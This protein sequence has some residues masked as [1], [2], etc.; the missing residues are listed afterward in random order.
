MARNASVG[1]ELAREPYKAKSVD[2]EYCQ[3]LS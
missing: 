1:V 3:R 2:G